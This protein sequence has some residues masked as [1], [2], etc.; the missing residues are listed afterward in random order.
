MHTGKPRAPRSLP[1]FHLGNPDE[2]TRA[3]SRTPSELFRPVDAQSRLEAGAGIAVISL[4]MRK[5]SWK[6]GLLIGGVIC[7]GLL[8]ALAAV[9]I[10]ANSEACRNRVIGSVNEMIHGRLAVGGH[11]VDVIAGRLVLTDVHLADTSGTTL[12]DAGRLSVQI[13]WTALLARTLHIV[14]LTIDEPFVSVIYDQQDRLNLLGM[15]PPDEARTEGQTDEAPGWQIRL[16][17]LR[18]SGGRFYL[19]QPT[20]RLRGTFQQ[21]DVT[22]RGDL[23]HRRAT[24]EVSIGRM[25][26]EIGEAA[27]T[28]NDIRLSA[29]YRPMEAQ[30]IRFVL[31]TPASRLT[32][33]GRLDLEKGQPTAALVGDV[34][35]DMEEVRQ[36][37]PAHSDVRGKARARVTLD[38]PLLDPSAALQLTFVNAGGWGV[39][40]RKLE[41]KALLDRRVVDIDRFT[42]E[43]RWGKIDLSGRLDLRP[44]FPHSFE[45]AV[46]GIEAVAVELEI[47]GQDVAP[48]LVPAIDTSWRGV[49]N[50]QMRLQGS[51]GRQS[52]PGGQ[53]EIELRV[54]NLKAGGATTAADGELVAYLSWTGQKVR[55][56][57]CQATVADTTLQAGGSVDWGAREVVASATVRSDR[58]DGLGEVLGLS[59]PSG[60]AILRVN[61]QG[62][63]QRPEAHGVLLTQEVAYAGWRVGRLLAEAD[64]KG[65]GILRFSRLVIQNSGSYL[66]GRGEMTLQDEDGRWLPD[67]SISA[68][69]ELASVTLSDFYAGVEVAASLNGRLRAD[70]TLA[71]PEATLDLSA[72]PIAWNGVEAQTRGRIVWEDGWLKVPDATLSSGKS[73][74]A[75]KGD[76]RWRAPDGGPWLSEPRLTAEVTSDALHLGDVRQAYGGQMTLQAKL[77]GTFS[78]LNGTYRIDGTDLDL[79]VQQLKSFHMSGRLADQVLHV[80]RIA[81]DVA[82]GQTIRG[83]GWYAFD[84]RIQARLTTEGFDLRHIDGAQRGG[85]VA[86]TVEGAIDARGTVTDPL[87]EGN[88][89]I[90][91]PEIY[92]QI[93]NGFSL[94]FAVRNH[95]LSVDAD[96]TFKLA[97]NGD[98]NSGDFE[99]MAEFDR[100]DVAPYLAMVSDQSWKGSV[101]GRLQ[102][103]GNWHRPERIDALVVLSDANLMFQE[104]ELLSFDRLEARLKDGA[105]QLPEAEMR[106]LQDG[107]LMVAADGSLHQRLSVRMGGRLPLAVIDPFS[108]AIANAAGDILFQLEGQGA[109]DRMNWRGELTLE[110]LEC[111]ISEVGQSVHAVN[112]EVAF[113]P[114]QVNIASI[115]GKLDDGSFRLDGRVGLVDMQP[116]S[117]DLRFQAQALP[118]HWPDTMDAKIAVDLALKGDARDALLSGRV[119]L[120]EGAYTKNVRLNLL[121]TLTERRRDEPVPSRWEAPDW[122]QRIRLGVTLTHRYPL[123]V[124]NNVAR[125]EVVPDLKL[126]GTAAR[127]VLNGRA[128]VTEGEVIFRKET[129]EVTRGVVDF[130]NPYKIEPTLDIQAETQIRKWR[131]R[132]SAQG[133]T[134]NLKVALSSDPPESDANILSLILL[135]RTSAELSDSSGGGATTKQMLAALAA[136]TFGE[137]IKKGI[138]VDILEVETETQADEDS[139]DRIQVTVGKKVTSRL[140]VKYAVE[141]KNNQLVQRAISEYRLLEHMSASGFQGTDGNY[142]GELL[143]RIEFR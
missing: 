136:S 139:S 86:G 91:R 101:T 58:I 37:L 16:E 39:S 124:D 113:T 74:L 4:P 137:D 107:H 42:A 92:G 40:A 28:L 95:H 61:A 129:F 10:Y 128:Q 35:V 26:M 44:V 122:M 87:I 98:L 52:D 49:W 19:E 117:A 132:L 5:R 27:G 99:V 36:W 17:R 79:R 115:S 70:G 131:I 32:L 100:T 109:W 34:D 23:H 22:G 80:E 82:P 8:S 50:G 126:S 54:E 46:A 41:L 140:T 14:S 48:H 102:A 121:S 90:R 57:S 31:A 134:E 97:A 125:M 81:V 67:P 84:R 141:S 133:T 20:A 21:V 73:S 77:T 45:Q 6:I 9:S 33:D 29:R 85:P 142:G 47:K 1:V 88:I 53:A 111:L 93:W 78:N 30:P 123:L 89:L 75:I 69:V 68:Q 83:D 127:P 60:K 72:S 3:A 110:A 130:V 24:S 11:R 96:L 118:L 104:I 143:F 18:I 15:V 55:M 138:G 108:D 13:R 120:L 103:R 105:I 51:L 63:W 106:L 65:D 71:H 12:A 59:L 56:D 119:V 7:G 116:E 38:G 64:L 112:G 62:P 94:D 76:V 135:G 114:E 66:E 43:D 25:D 2:T